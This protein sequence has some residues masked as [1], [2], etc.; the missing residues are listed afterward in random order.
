[1]PDSRL[2]PELV[3]RRMTAMRSAR[4]FLQRVIADNVRLFQAR[5]VPRLYG[6]GIRYRRPK[7][8]SDGKQRILNAAEVVQAGE[9]TCVDLACY[10]AAELCAVGDARIGVH[11]CKR[12]KSGGC[13]HGYLHINGQTIPACPNV[14]LYYRPHLE[15]IYHVEVRLPNGDAEDPS[16][17]LGMGGSRE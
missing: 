13:E 4:E 3:A 14:K 9:G 12:S 5:K 11:A 15:G 16:R 17:F 2:P 7:L 1:M 10:R 8:G 6:S